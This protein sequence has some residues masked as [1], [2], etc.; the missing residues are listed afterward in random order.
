VLADVLGATLLRNAIYK[1]IECGAPWGMSI[2][3]RDR[4]VFYLVVRGSAR[5]EVEGDSPRALSAGDAVFIPHGT[6]HVVRDAESSKPESVCDGERHCR[7]LTRVG[8]R[9]VGG[10]GAAT[11][12]VAGFFLFS[13][14][15]PVLLESMPRTILL[16]ATDPAQNRWISATLQLLIAES[17]APGPASSL[18]LQR[19]ADVLFVQTLRTLATHSERNPRGLPALADPAIHQA[20]GV[21]HGDVASPWT[22]AA[23][24]KH[25]GLSRSAFAARFTALVGEPPLQYLVRWRMARAAEL[26]RDTRA[27]IGEVAGSVGYESVPSF[28]KAFRKWVGESPTTFRER[29]APSS[30]PKH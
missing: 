23:L 4:A 6:A 1:R 25:A 19:L 27:R 24:A 11:S 21:L 5:F 10:D 14:R 28:N 7:S 8:V 20:L 9:R 18:V 13:G 3:A 15:R 16:M 2:P 29:H 17:A 26:L 12:L 22:V 30:P